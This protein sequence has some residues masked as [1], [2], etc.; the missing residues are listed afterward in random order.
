MSSGNPE[1][2]PAEL[3]VYLVGPATAVI[4]GRDEEMRTEDLSFAERASSLAVKLQ[5]VLTSVTSKTREAADNCD[6][7]VVV[8]G[9]FALGSSIAGGQAQFNASFKLSSKSTP[10]VINVR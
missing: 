6:W 9:T 7:E 1:E 3:D 10:T 4:S 8:S 5:D 2:A